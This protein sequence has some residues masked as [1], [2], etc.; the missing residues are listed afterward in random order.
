MTSTPPLVTIVTP[1]FNCERFIAETYESIR[2]QSLTQWEW[3]VI[4]DASTDATP[5][6]L[7][8]ISAADPRVIF[9]RLPHNLGAASVRNRCITAAK[10]RFIAF[11]DAD[12]MWHAEKLDL[13]CSIM[14][15]KGA[16]LT[17][18]AYDIVD[19]YSNLRGHVK[20]PLTT[21][22]NSLLKHNVIGCLT[23][24]Y[25][26]FHFGKVVMPTM[27]K[28]QDYALWLKLLRNGDTAHAV[29]GT[30]ATY[31]RRRGSLSSN[32]ISAAA[33]TWLVYRQAEKLNVPRSAYYFAHY[34]TGSV[35]RRA[36]QAWS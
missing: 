35:L 4:D 23:A 31:R 11:L 13:Q 6:I 9:D 32:K 29:P 19:E 24:M 22:Y 3:R 16:V 33:A 30:I 7:S 36:R 12:D 34:A 27:R 2:G 8:K 20:V 15:K 25:D 17:Y 1:A 21:D 5:K 28:R 14:R 18:G 10:G 26:T